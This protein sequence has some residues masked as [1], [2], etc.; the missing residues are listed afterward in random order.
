MSGT[1]TYLV[2]YQI[3]NKTKQKPVV[4]IPIY[5]HVKLV[6]YLFQVLHYK[7]PKIIFIIFGVISKATHHHKRNIK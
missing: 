6:W 4:Y 1:P 2:S 7:F 3:K 5:I